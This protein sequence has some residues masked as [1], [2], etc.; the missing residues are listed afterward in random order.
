[1][2]LCARRS[3]SSCVCVLGGVGDHVHVCQEEWAII[4]LCFRRSGR[5]CV[6]VLGGVGDHVFVC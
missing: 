2:C 1:M 4:C 5:S 6:G 3:G